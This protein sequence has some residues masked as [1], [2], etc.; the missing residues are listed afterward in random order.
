LVCAQVID[1]A[2]GDSGT[3]PQI[4][5]VT[6]IAKAVPLTSDAPLPANAVPLA[7]VRV[8]ANATTITN[9]NITD[10]RKSASVAHGIRPMMPGDSLSETA[11]R[12]GE[13]R[14]STALTNGF[15]V[16]RYNGAGWDPVASVNPWQTWT[17]T[18]NGMTNNSGV[19]TGR[20]QRV[21][22]I[23]TV[24]VTFNPNPTADLGTNDIYITLPFV[25]SSG[26]SHFS[27]GS[28]YLFDASGLLRPMLCLVGAN[29]NQLT[30]WGLNGSAWMTLGNAGYSWGNSSQLGADITYEVA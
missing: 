29:L 27:S 6:G 16:E 24:H 4:V 23:C 25:A 18:M 5:V 7:Y 22:K 9:A 8:N 10:V 1:S 26:A 20:Y 11:Y 21:G 28:G 19:F 30:L 13:L 2:Q 12:V 3:Q 15:G 17:P 14:D